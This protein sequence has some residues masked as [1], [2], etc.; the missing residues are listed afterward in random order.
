MADQP[1]SAPEGAATAAP[2][3][4]EAPAFAIERIYIKDLSIENP[5]AP[6]SFQ[7]AEAP[8][9]EIG[10]RTRGAGSTTFLAPRAADLRAAAFFLTAIF[11]V[12]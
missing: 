7:L 8:A 3:N 1:T 2:T 4:G 12:S 5:G 9:V 11:L 6:Q 10:L